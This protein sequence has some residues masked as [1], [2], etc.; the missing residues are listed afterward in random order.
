MM[1]ARDVILWLDLVVAWVFVL[2]M[3]H[4]VRETRRLKAAGGPGGWSRFLYTQF[5][6]GL[7]VMWVVSFGLFWTGTV[8]ERRWL[9]P[10]RTIAVTGT[11]LFIV[12]SVM[13]LVRRRSI[14]RQLEGRGFRVCAGCQYDLQ[15]SL[16]AGHC[17]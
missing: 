13:S 10:G 11:S 17:P 7:K 12:A 6:P 9:L 8:L 15:G 2:V 4:W 16:V 5:S 1:T 14:K 3:V